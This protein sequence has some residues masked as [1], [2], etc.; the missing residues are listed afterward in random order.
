MS[1][2]D[3]IYTALTTYWNAVVIAK[4]AFTKGDKQTLGSSVHQCHIKDDP[5]SVYEHQSLQKDLLIEKAF[6][7]IQATTTTDIAAYLAE[8]RRIVNAHT[9]DDVEWRV[10]K[11]NISKTPQQIKLIIEVTSL[12]DG[13]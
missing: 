8:I 13:V 2:E 12:T 9:T 5:E 1:L 4:P 7:S 3:D 11:K 6:I 10:T